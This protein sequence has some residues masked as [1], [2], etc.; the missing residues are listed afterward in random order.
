MNRARLHARVP[1]IEVL[2]L[3]VRMSTLTASLMIYRTA[4]SAT[5]DASGTPAPLRS[6]PFRGSR[7]GEGTCRTVQ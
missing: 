1:S 6:T 5:R 4:K 2:R 7:F 3:V